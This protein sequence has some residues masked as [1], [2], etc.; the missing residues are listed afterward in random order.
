MKNKITP[1]TQ[2]QS[3]LPAEPELPTR[4]ITLHFDIPDIGQLPEPLATAFA[5]CSAEAQMLE[6]AIKSAITKDIHVFANGGDQISFLEVLEDVSLGQAKNIAVGTFSRK[7]KNGKDIGKMIVACVGF[8]DCVKMQWS[9]AGYPKSELIRVLKDAVDRRNRIMHQLLAEVLHFACSI[10]D[11]LKFLNES[12]TLFSEI[13]RLIVTADGL[14][15]KLGSV[16]S[17][18]SSMPRFKIT[19]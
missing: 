11:A 17:D 13:R 19:L 3:N 12:R 14:S 18:G 15:S 10:E 9:A 7:E 6:R 2:E 1:L 4:S 16:A 8:F 5:H